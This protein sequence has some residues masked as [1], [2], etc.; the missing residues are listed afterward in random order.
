MPIS[1]RFKLIPFVATVLLVTLGIQLGNWQERRAA[2]KISAQDKLAQGNLAGPLLLDG[3]PLDAGAVEFRRVTATGRF[4]ADWPLYLDNRPYQGRSGFYVLMPFKIAG[5][6]MHVLVQRGWLPRD[7]AQH[8]KLPAYIT[9]TGEVTLEGVARL[10]PGR[11]MQ[12]GTAPPLAPNAIVQNADPLHVAE[13]SGLT[14]QPFVLQQTAPAKPGG[15]DAGMARDWALP[16]MS[17]EKHQGYAFQWYALAA[18]AVVFFV[19]NGF[20]RAKPAK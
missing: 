1:F 19:V 6:G 11:V 20:R 5:S 9:P 14:M 18:M 4:V 13:Q 10:N 2:Q 8:D 17:V 16:A 12:L 15:D 3:K 7:S